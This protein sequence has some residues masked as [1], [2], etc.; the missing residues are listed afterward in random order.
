M[1]KLITLL[2]W[3][4]V[5][6]TLLAQ[7]SVSST[8]ID[9]IIKVGYSLRTTKPDSV[10]AVANSAYKESKQ[11]KYELGIT[12]AKTLAASY[13]IDKCQLDTAKFLLNGALQ[14][15]V[16]F[17]KYKNSIEYGYVFLFLGYLAAKEFEF[18]LATHYAN[19]AHNTFNA[20]ES[21]ENISYALGLL[22]EIEYNLGNYAKA[23]AYHSNAI[24]LKIDNKIPEE[25]H[26]FDL[27]N[28]A[29]IYL[30]IGQHEK[31][32]LYSQKALKLSQKHNVVDKSLVNLINLAA[33][34]FLQK[35]YDS[36]LYFNNE[37][38]NLASVFNKNKIKLV[39]LL[40]ISKVHNKLG[41]Y[42]D[43]KKIVNHILRSTHSD[44]LWLEAEVLLSKNFLKLN[45]ID[46]SLN[47]AIKL[48]KRNNWHLENQ[49]LKLE[50]INVLAF[51]YQNL[52]KYDSALHFMNS[53]HVL[54]D[55]LNNLTKQ[56]KLSALYAELESLEKEKEIE[57]LLK[58]NL[59]QKK[60]QA[61]MYIIISSSALVVILMSVSVV[62]FFRNKEKNEKIKN[63]ELKQQLDK[64][65]RDLNQQTLKIIYMNNG[66]L[67]IEGNLKKMQMQFDTNHAKD[68][69]QML[70]TIRDGKTLEAEWENLTL[71]F[72]Q[73][74]DQFSEKVTHRF[75]NLSTSEKRLI[76][77]IKM[78]LRNK[79]IASLLN[80]DASSVKMAKYRLKKKLQLPEEIEVQQY[81]NNIN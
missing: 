62:L 13:Y 45:Q 65:K 64:K 40:N 31:S 32:I 49:E 22:G 69:D 81:L 47:T 78:D 20:I 43:S 77:L 2:L 33:A 50:I 51:A 38:I 10:L 23:L 76:L 42:Q 53:Y 30:K 79:E 52:K 41:N 1:T 48:Y 3:L 18:T 19:S 71:Y 7:P 11:A 24:R 46:S 67:E 70:K 26:I 6:S 35:K 17:P 9:E 58:D 60:K 36:A 55:S 8:E 57:I 16:R 34:Y 4:H 39:A 73:V 28:I 61:G 56:Q 59:V 80:I 15:F 27:S 21:K 14:Y 29:T 63:N 44:E 75:P 54:A 68:I 5:T 66:L 37:C 25:R 74:Y 12:Q 72:D